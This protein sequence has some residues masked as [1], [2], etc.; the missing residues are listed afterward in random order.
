MAIRR[1]P[2]R[3]LT[4]PPAHP[5]EKYWKHLCSVAVCPQWPARTGGRAGGRAD[6]GPDIL[7]CSEQ[8][9]RF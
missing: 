7:K 9:K 6:G 1:P 3:P 4:R 2:A 8:S 5:P